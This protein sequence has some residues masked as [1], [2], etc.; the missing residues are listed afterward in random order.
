MKISVITPVYNGEA[1]IKHCMDSVSNQTY[2]NREHVIIDGL[3]SDKTATV[4]NGCA[5]THVKFWSEKDNGMY[6]A[7]NKGIE[8][9]DG[10]VICF[11]CADDMYAHKSVLQ[12]IADTFESHSDIDILYGDII[13]VDRNDL[14]KVTRYWKSCQ[15]KPGLFKKGWL[16]PNT[17]L[18]I[19][20]DVFKKYG[21]FSCK[22]KMASDYEL[23]YRFFEKYKIK[24][25]YISDIMVRMRS[26]G[27]SNSSLKN[28]Y[29]SL[30]EC[31]GALSDHT[32]RFP[33][34]Y[35]AN[36]LLYRLQQ[37]V[38]PSHVKRL[39]REQLQ[40]MQQAE[41]SSTIEV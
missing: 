29:T 30:S 15:F 9:A 17:A 2:A 13:Y 21:P 32:V 26:G 23:Q 6:D 41:Y 7:F 39:N 34:L 1:V 10:D 8:M 11:L 3:S 24:S 22:F 18:F 37:T 36:T 25:L 12:T 4:V 40:L 20:Q 38:V 31:Y 5:N 16:P 19:R 33:L 28:M 35:I 27:V 14:S